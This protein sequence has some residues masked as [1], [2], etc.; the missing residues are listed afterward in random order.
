MRPSSDIN[1]KILIK[2]IE[3]LILFDNGLQSSTKL[4]TEINI[5]PIVKRL[6]M[7]VVKLQIKIAIGNNIP[8]PRIVIL[9]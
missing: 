3:S 9:E 2:C 8:P 7:P 4:I 5:N 6:K 1:K